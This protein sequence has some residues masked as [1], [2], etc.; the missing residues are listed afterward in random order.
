MKN[1]VI[2][3]TFIVILCCPQLARGDQKIPAT[4]K[5][6]PWKGIKLGSAILDIGGT[7]RLRGEMQ[8]ETNIRTYGTG[9]KEDYILSR[10]RL[11]RN[12]QLPHAIRLHT[13]IQD[14]EAM[15]LSFSDKDFAPGNNPYHDPFDINQ[16]YIEYRPVK[17][18]T[19]HL[20]AKG[21]RL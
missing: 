6:H 19:A 8:D 21:E 12:L 13:Q 10:L 3:P 17:G 9:T 5:D 4:K 2:L 11:D 14:A 1:W 20:S 16:A 15:G 18:A 7:Y